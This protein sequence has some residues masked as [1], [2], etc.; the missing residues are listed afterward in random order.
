MTLTKSTGW[1]NP[2][3][4][5]QYAKYNNQTCSAWSRLEMVKVDE[6]RSRKNPYDLSAV[7]YNLTSS[8]RSALMY[9]YNFG[10]NIPSQATITKI[11]VKTCVC[12]DDI[13]ASRV[14]TQIIKLKVGANLTDSGVGNNL[15]PAQPWRTHKYANQIG[16]MYETVGDSTSSVKSVWGVDVTPA[17]VNNSNFGI[18]FQAMGNGSHK[19]KAYVDNIQVSI[20]YTLPEETPIVT[21]P[22]PVPVISNIKSSLSVIKYDTLNP[23][24]YTGQTV[25][26]QSYDSTTGYHF[27]VKFKNEVQVVNNTKV[28]SNQNSNPLI[29]ETDGLTIFPG[30]TKQI[31]VPSMLIKGTTDSRY[32]KSDDFPLA[33]DYIEQFYDVYVYSNVVDFDKYANGR[34]FIESTVKLY[35]TKVV[36]GK[37]VK[38][39]LLDDI[40]FKLNSTTSNIAN[41]QTILEN[42]KFVNNKANKG[43]AIY[44]LGRLY[45]KNLSFKN[46][47]TYGSNKN[48][49]QFFDVNI[50]RDGEFE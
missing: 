32:F 36:D 20:D 46:N 35:S 45:V 30:G 10:F 27:W 4:I 6:P 24:V 39:T 17:I 21:P 49:C 18:V 25:I 38:D 48:N 2:N 40:T 37:T 15:A 23:T 41:S 11:M 13:T 16:M 7:C 31:I 14:R 44:N 22:K 9:C 42:C 19:H 5:N 43:A 33:P 47:T 26:S 29:L 8:K 12:Q 28:I 34:S 50:C 3:T 1:K